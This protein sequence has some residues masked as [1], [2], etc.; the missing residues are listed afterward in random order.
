M[1][2]KNNRSKTGSVVFYITV[3]LLTVGI[4]AMASLPY[5]MSR[6]GRNAVAGNYSGEYPR[7]GDGVDKFGRPSSD[8][9]E[10]RGVWVA[11]LS[12]NG[13]NRKLI[14]TIV[15]SAKA[16]GMNTIFLH[17]RPF[18]DALYQ[19]DY[20]PWSH[21]VT[22]TQGQAPE[23]GF[24]PL[25]YAVE[26]AHREGMYLHAWLN[27]LRIMLPSGT[28]PPSL[29]DDNPYNVWRNDD[30][31]D[32]DDWVIDYKSGKFYNPAVPQVRELIVNGTREIVER[33]NVD[34]VHWDDYFYPAYDETFD[35]GKA[36]AAYKEQGGSLGLSDWRRQ[37]INELVK[38]VYS[39]V[40][41]ADSQ[42]LFGISPAG[43][44][45]NCMSAGADVKTWG[46]TEG[47]VDYLIPQVYWTSDNT[48]APFEPVCR[49]W[50]ELVKSS[51]VKLYIGLALY[52]AGSDDDKGKWKKA[53]D[54]IMN[55]VL[56]TR[57]GE[58]QSEG[59]VLYSYAYF[60]SEQTAEE[61]KNLRS[62]LVAQD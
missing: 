17:V 12:L 47:Y 2:Q 31:A 52:K 10:M 44:I 51:G 11:Y 21:L 58:I 32:N 34:G 4:A 57:S 16:N 9:D 54:I 61:M 38:A 23:D 60:D 14:D 3:A 20:Y 40:K 41:S 55:Q 28:Y 49:Q 37:N 46:S 8:F 19:S 50:N 18:G 56:Y 42:C 26:A 59:F 24:D 27:P 29:S 39:A 5:I 1:H 15:S 22:G 48:V 13:V 30:M 7:N 6:S 36:Y 53:D 33:Y 43:N 35:D 62:V 45:D 25:A